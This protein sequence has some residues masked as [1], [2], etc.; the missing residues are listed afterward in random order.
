MQHYKWG[1]LNVIW[2]GRDNSFAA[3]TEQHGE[4]Q[5]FSLSSLMGK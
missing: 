3:I 1:F 4:Q 2:L 5:A